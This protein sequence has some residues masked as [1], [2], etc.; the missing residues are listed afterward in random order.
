MLSSIGAKIIEKVLSM[1]VSFLYDQAVM[2]FEKKVIQK[3]VSESSNM[4][5][6]VEA[7][8]RINDLMSS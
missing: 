1:I 6:R 3:T 4:E 8:N 5:D 2:F 7:S